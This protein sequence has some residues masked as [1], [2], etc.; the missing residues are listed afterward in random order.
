M[1]ETVYD[2]SRR[3]IPPYLWTCE[4]RKQIDVPKYKVRG[5]GVG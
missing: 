1:C 3:K 4:T 5:A 2:S